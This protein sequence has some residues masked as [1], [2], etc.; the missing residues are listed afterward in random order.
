MWHPSDTWCHHSFSC[1]EGEVEPFWPHWS[2]CSWMAKINPVSLAQFIHNSPIWAS[3]HLSE[4]VRIPT[5][6][7]PGGCFLHPLTAWAFFWIEGEPQMSKLSLHKWSQLFTL[8]LWDP[9]GLQQESWG[10]A[11]LGQG[12][13]TWERLGR[14][15]DSRLITQLLGALCSDLRTAIM[16]Q[17]GDRW[18]LA[19]PDPVGFFVVKHCQHGARS[20]KWPSQTPLGQRQSR[21]PRDPRLAGVQGEGRD[22]EERG[23]QSVSHATCLEA[24][25]NGQD[26]GL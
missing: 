1:L 13:D 21:A 12:S 3:V 10:Q 19:D 6:V 9:P 18:P 26:H 22:S 24:V 20:A 16:S 17:A 25:S 5:P 14:E 4:V 23:L 8:E 11:V 15:S 2:F 7:L